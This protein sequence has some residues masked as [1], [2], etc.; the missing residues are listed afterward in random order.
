M[1]R[2]TATWVNG[3]QF[4]AESESGHGLIMDA[5]AAVG[6]RNTGP[7]P[8]ELLLAG[9]AG[10]TGI[11]VVYI[12]TDKM[13]KE[14]TS[15]EI[16]VSGERA[17]EPPKVYTDIQVTYRIKGPNLKEK[18]AVRAIRLSSENYC[19]VSIMLAKTAKIQVAYEITDEVSGE[20]WQGALGD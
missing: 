7:A 13:K 12:L 9:L 19:S 11:D 8:M 16:Q 20:T 1:S 14:L 4:V 6:G 17:I 3:K 15:L 10:C 18:D 5:G 2:V